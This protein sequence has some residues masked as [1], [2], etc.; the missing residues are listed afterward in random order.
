[1][2]SVKDELFSGGFPSKRCRCTGQA[3]VNCAGHRARASPTQ[4]CPCHEP[5][6]LH[7][8]RASRTCAQPLGITLQYKLANWMRQ[9]VAG[10]SLIS[11]PG[12]SATLILENVALRGFVVLSDWLQRYDHDGKYARG[13]A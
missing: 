11:L 10:T 12:A 13:G 5:P 8:M 6:W 3:C 4:A 9:S 7:I 2:R 1:M